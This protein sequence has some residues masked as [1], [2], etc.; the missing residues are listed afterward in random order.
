MGKT[1]TVPYTHLGIWKHPHARGEDSADLVLTAN[2]EETPPR[3]WGRLGYRLTNRDGNR[4]TPT[5]VGKTSSSIRLSTASKKHPHARGED[6]ACVMP[7]PCVVETPPRAW[8]RLAALL[9]FFGAIRNTP[10]RV[11]KTTRAGCAPGFRRKHPHARGEDAVTMP[12]ATPDTETPPRAWGRLSRCQ[13]SRHQ[14]RNTPT[15]VGK[16]GRHGVGL[17]SSGKHPHARGEDGARSWI[18]IQ[19]LETPPRAWGRRRVPRCRPHRR[20]NTPTRVGKT[21]RPSRR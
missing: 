4:N 14:S 1:F 21:E 13:L 2:K 5:R 11:G 15:R 7:T 8:G 20:G 10:T 17:I 19:Y 16:T 3:A 6:T 9:F 18:N 12:C